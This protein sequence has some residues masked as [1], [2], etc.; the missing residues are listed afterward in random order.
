MECWVSNRVK[1]VYGV[2]FLKNCWKIFKNEDFGFK[3][4]IIIDKTKE[5][6][7]KTIPG[8]MSVIFIIIDRTF[9]HEY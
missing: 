5:S 2:H 3:I 6:L 4:F 7:D 1:S 8:K 9:I